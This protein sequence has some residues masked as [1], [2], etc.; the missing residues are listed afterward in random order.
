MSTYYKILYN[1]KITLNTKYTHLTKC[2]SMQT[3]TT[4]SAI[5]QTKC[6]KKFDISDFDCGMMVSVRQ[7]GLNI[8][9]TVDLLGFPYTTVSRVC[10][11]WCKK[12]TTS[13]EQQLCR[14]KHL[15]HKRR[16][17]RLVKAVRKAGSSLDPG[18][19]GMFSE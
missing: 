6:Q 12:Q 9:E 17:A 11:E 18:L 19:R 8:S 5:F 4:G 15:V 3:W 2:K 7:G 14:Q 16:R 10:R 13:N 1:C